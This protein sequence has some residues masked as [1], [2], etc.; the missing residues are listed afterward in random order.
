LLARV[1][2]EVERLL[3]EHKLVNVY[4]DHLEAVAHSE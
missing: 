3:L 1:W 2:P 4:P